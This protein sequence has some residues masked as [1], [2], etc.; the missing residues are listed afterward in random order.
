MKVVLIRALTV[1][2]LLALSV[3][4]HAMPLGLWW[5]GW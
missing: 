2:G 4:A 1:A 5:L 3:P